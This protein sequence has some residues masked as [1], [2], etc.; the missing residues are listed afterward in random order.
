[1]RSRHRPGP[2]SL[3]LRLA[4][5]WIRNVVDE[6]HRW[7]HGVLSPE[8]DS[9]GVAISGVANTRGCCT[10]SL[11]VETCAGTFVA[12]TP[13]DTHTVCIACHRLLPIT[14]WASWT[15]PGATAVNHVLTNNSPARFRPVQLTAAQQ[16]LN[17]AL[18]P[19]RRNRLLDKVNAAIEYVNAI[20]GVP[21]SP[22]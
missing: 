17:R 21:V 16:R 4:S 3:S 2:A 12:R 9:G 22:G 19:W 20:I 1:M 5:V 10:D 8:P 7:G 15:G 14:L 6:L 11:T 18:P 13:P